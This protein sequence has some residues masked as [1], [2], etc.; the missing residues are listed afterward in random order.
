MSSK[1]R[2]WAELAGIALVCLIG[3]GAAVVAI[4]WGIGVMLPDPQVDM[5]PAFMPGIDHR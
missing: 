1:L 5:I 4:A 2:R 3:E